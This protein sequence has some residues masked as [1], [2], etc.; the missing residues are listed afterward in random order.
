MRIFYFCFE[1]FSKLGDI[2]NHIRETVSWLSKFGHEVHFFNPSIASPH[3]DT[4]VRIHR[5][6]LLNIPLINWLTFEIASLKSLIIYIMRNR[7]NALYFRETSSITPLIISKLFSIPLIIE[8]NG[9]VLDELE[10]VNY[11]KWK[12][13]YM[14]SLQRL[15]FV[16]CTR[17]ISV[18]EGLKRLIE[19]NY[20]INT[21]KIIAIA[22]GTNPDIFRPLSRTQSRENTGLDK[23]ADTVGF[24]GSCYHYHGVQHLIKAAPLV[25][26][27]KDDI[28]FVI[29]GDGAQRDNWIAMTEEL[30][31]RDAFI[32]P[33]AV[34]F[35]KAPLYINSYDVCIAPWD[36]D[37]LKNVGLSP[38][39]L[40]DYMSCQKPV[41]CSPVYGV[42]EIVNKYDCGVTVDVKDPEKFA[43]RILQLIKNSS[44]MRD[45]GINARNV[46]LQHFTWE[47]TSRKIETVIR[48]TYAAH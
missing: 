45:L 35:H 5:I 8:V 39:K 23:N 14:R 29:A 34:P 6:P 43:E 12:L 32:F 18:S 28:K 41:L 44:R 21:D 30:G 1:G 19:E 48:S 47:K 3:F 20:P 40:F 17:I 27:Q 13:I 31:I 15:N 42:N 9:W 10:Q 2:N 24:I 11:P 25:L 22:N 26:E 4:D 38:M 7:P 36:I 46:V 37:L 33:G 16:Y